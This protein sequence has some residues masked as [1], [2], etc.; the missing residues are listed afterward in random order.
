MTLVSE[1]PESTMKLISLIKPLLG[2]GVL[3]IYYATS[4]FNET[5]AKTTVAPTSSASSI[6]LVD[7]ASTI[8][9]S[10][11]AVDVF[12]TEP[13]LSAN[14]PEDNGKNEV[15]AEQRKPVK[16]TM[17]QGLIMNQVISTYA[18]SNVRNSLCAEHVEEFKVGLRAFEPWALQ[19]EFF[20]FTII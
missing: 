17:K 7:N 15:I 18:I 8:N 19:S 20:L 11:D 4:A 16:L 10:W 6:E 14:H 13:N 3:G 9:G 2:L 5:T 12:G 1:K